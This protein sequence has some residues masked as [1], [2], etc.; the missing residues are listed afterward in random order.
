KQLVAQ[1]EALLVGDRPDRD[2]DGDQKGDSRSALA[3]QWHHPAGLAN[4]PQA[5]P[6]AGDVWSL[7]QV[8]HGGDYLGGPVGHCLAPPVP[9]G[10]AYSRLVPRERGVASS[11]EDLP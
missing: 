9:R 3:D 10:L 7:L 11:R 6:V 2:G 5:D 8:L 1:A 4:P